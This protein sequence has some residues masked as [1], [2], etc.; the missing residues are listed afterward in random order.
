ML[1]NYDI[2][3]F[4]EYGCLP[5]L[6][7]PTA[8]TPIMSE[9]LTAYQAAVTAVR[10][11]AKLVQEKPNDE[12]PALFFLAEDVQDEERETLDCLVT[13]SAPQLAEVLVNAGEQAPRLA[14]AIVGSA[15]HLKGVALQ[16]AAGRPWPVTS[17]SKP[18]P[19]V[20]DA[21]KDA[22]ESWTEDEVSPDHGWEPTHEST[23]EFL[24]L[25][26]QM[27][28]SIVATNSLPS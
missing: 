23:V 18:E 11:Y 20:I 17:S 24:T 21:L 2:M 27:G 8:P 7:P 9:L 19:V 4:E 25:L 12:R 10:T 6:T 22:L 16:Y 26:G 14:C 28:Y 3:Q 13:G 15:E 1:S 5:A